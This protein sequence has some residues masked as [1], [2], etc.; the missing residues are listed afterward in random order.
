MA[1]RVERIPTGDALPSSP[2]MAYQDSYLW[3]LRQ[4]VGNDLVLM[5]GAMVALQR[6]D[7]RVLLTQAIAALKR[8]QDTAERA[9]RR[10][11]TRRTMLPAES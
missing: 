1:W 2:A 4:I 7:Q 6:D 9:A 11:Q 5:P 3:R 10:G 8:W